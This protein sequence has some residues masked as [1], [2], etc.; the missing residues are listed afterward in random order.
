MSN[1]FTAY[2]T[3]GG[4][5]RMTFTPKQRRRFAK[6]TNRDRINGAAQDMGA[7]RP[8][9]VTKPAGLSGH[10]GRRRA[11]LAEIEGRSAA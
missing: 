5:I 9:N 6:K 4:V 8:G 1:Y 7:L 3:R 10:P 2:V 11:Q